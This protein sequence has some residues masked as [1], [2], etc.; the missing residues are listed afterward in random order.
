MFLQTTAHYLKLVHYNNSDEYLTTKSP[1][2]KERL[3]SLNGKLGYLSLSLIFC[4]D[5][6]S[7]LRNSIMLCRD[8]YQ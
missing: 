7:D 5:E 8:T 2:K 6:N 1:W 3:S 4:E